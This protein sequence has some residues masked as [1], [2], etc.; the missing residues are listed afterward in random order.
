DNKQWLWL[1][2]CRRTK[3]IVGYYI[4]DRGIK[5]CKQFSA[6]IAPGYQNL[7]TKSDM[8]KAYNKTFD[9]SLHECSEYRGETSHIE[10][11]NATVRARMGRLVRKSLS[12]SKQQAMHISAI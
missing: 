4:G 2:L 8:W 7:I 12:F 1:A 3:Q 6:N 11:C 5:A 9:P 10:R